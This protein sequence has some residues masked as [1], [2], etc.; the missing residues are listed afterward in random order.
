MKLKRVYDIP[1]GWEPEIEVAVDSK[2]API[3]DENLNTIKRV[4]NPPPVK[5]VIVQNT[6]ISAEQN[7]STGLVASALAEGW[8]ELHDDELI[9]KAEP[10]DLKY[11]VLREPGRYCLHCGEKLQ[12][13][14]KGELARIHVLSK[15]NGKSSP[16]ASVPAGYVWITAYECVLDAKQHAKFKAK[17][18]GEV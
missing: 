16:D 14:I 11:K 1:E 5:G 2:G 18:I 10:E 15:H 8:M 7:F 9:V 4:V 3:L 17:K 12:D 13:D 6:G